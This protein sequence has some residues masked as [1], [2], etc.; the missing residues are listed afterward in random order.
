MVISSDIC[1]NSNQKDISNV[2]S[3]KKKRKV[4]IN[5]QDNE[6]PILLQLF[7]TNENIQQFHSSFQ[8]R[9]FFMNGSKVKDLSSLQLLLYNYNVKEILDNT[10][11][12][13]IHVWLKGGKEEKIQSITLDDADQAVKLYNVG[14]SLYCRAPKIIEELVVPKLLK[15]LG[16]GIANSSTDRYRRGEI[17]IFFSKKGHITEYHLDF[18]ENFTI[19]LTGQKKWYFNTST[20]TMPLRG[21]TP[22]YNASSSNEISETQLKTLR[23]SNPTF[24]CDEYS[25]NSN[26]SCIALNPGDILYHPAGLW[27]RVE[28]LE[29]SISINISLIATSSNYAEVFCNNLQQILLQNK[30]WRSPIRTG[31]QAQYKSSHQI[32]KQ[33]IETIPKILGNISSEDVLPSNIFD[34]LNLPLKESNEDVIENEEN[35]QSEL[36][37]EIESDSS[38]PQTQVLYS[39]VINIEDYYNDILKKDISFPNYSSGITSKRKLSFN[40]FDEV[41]QLNF[42]INKCGILLREKDLK[43]LGDWNISKSFDYKDALVIHQG[44]GNEQFESIAYTVVLIHECH[45][46]IMNKF[47]LIYNKFRN[48]WHKYIESACSSQLDCIKNSNVS[49]KDLMVSDSSKDKNLYKE[50]IIQFLFTLHAAG[51]IYSIK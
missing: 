32:M 16:Y 5:L 49:V 45:I 4:K 25:N 6:T 39:D 28:C 33:L 43:K 8:C 10:A 47:M 13:K 19:H 21:A 20:A 46:E 40:I 38:S 17:E 12:E 15:E 24:Q 29:D 23:L 51:I 11:S 35:S 1:F 26:E 34:Y 31:N 14:H 30:K 3:D 22:H 41:S 50:N 7:E 18:Q 27:H 37:S 48:S 42:Q 36:E 9:P 2:K 44:Y